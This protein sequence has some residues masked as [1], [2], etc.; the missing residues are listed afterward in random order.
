MTTDEKRLL[1]T[2]VTEEAIRELNLDRSKIKRVLRG[3]RYKTFY[4][5]EVDSDLYFEIKRPD[6]RYEKRATRLA[7]DIRDG[8]LKLLYIDE[9]RVDDDSNE[10]APFD[11]PSDID[12]EQEAMDH[13]RDEAIK[14]AL[15]KLSEKERALIHLLFFEDYTEREA[16]SKI[17]ISQKTVNNRKKK[18]L[19]KL[20]KDLKDYSDAF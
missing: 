16:A 7:K 9:E 12:I 1:E 20:K 11:I 14:E 2:E 10:K 17:G 13:L 15:N 8:K 4:Y 18:I 3:S 5:E 19:E 6:W